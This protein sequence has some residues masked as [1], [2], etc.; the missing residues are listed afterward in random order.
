MIFFNFCLKYKRIQ[1][2]WIKNKNAS[3]TLSIRLSKVY[4]YYSKIIQKLAP[5]LSFFVVTLK[6]ISKD[7]SKYLILFYGNIYMHPP[8]ILDLV[9]F[10]SKK[11]LGSTHAFKTKSLTT[12]TFKIML[13]NYDSVW[14][15]KNSSVYIHFLDENLVRLVIR[16]SVRRV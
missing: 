14:H 12:Y 6:E 4:Y 16:F 9:R 7:Q 5:N 8:I 1:F 3:T 13:G 11:N 15:A 10:L 2:I